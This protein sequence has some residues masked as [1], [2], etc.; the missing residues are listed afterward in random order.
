M[1][2]IIAKIGEKNI[3]NLFNQE[4]VMYLIIKANKTI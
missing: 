1:L 4:K 2:K 3:I